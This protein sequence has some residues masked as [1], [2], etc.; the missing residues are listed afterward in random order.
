[1]RM[2][3]SVHV[4][5][6]RGHQPHLST[7]TLIGGFPPIT[8]LAVLPY[9]QLTP[10]CHPHIH[11]H[12]H[13]HTHTL[14]HTHAHALAHAKRTCTCTHTP[15]AHACMH[16]HAHTH[17]PHCMHTHTRT[18]ACTHMQTRAHPHT[19]HLYTDHCLLVGQVRLPQT[20][21]RHSRAGQC[22]L[23]SSSSIYSPNNV[24][25]FMYC[26]VFCV[27]ILPFLNIVQPAKEKV[28]HHLT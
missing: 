23:V 20:P 4:L 7:R 19:A 11:V 10:L 25:F 24:D 3:N 13:T 8:S 15:H 22:G 12:V 6:F 26:V 21:Q 1:M 9:M 17:I 28:V 16:A 2:C 18:Y 14:V 27:L 5:K